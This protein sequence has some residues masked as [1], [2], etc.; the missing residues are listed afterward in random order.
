[1]CSLRH[2]SKL[3]PTE[4]TS[5]P[6]FARDKKM[7]AI[8]D[9]FTAVVAERFG[10]ALLTGALLASVL[11][12][13]V[14]RQHRYVTIFGVLVISV[15]STLLASYH[16]FDSVSLDCDDL[17]VCTWTERYGLLNPVRTSEIKVND[18]ESADFIRLERSSVG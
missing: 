7:T 4:L 14:V 10:E 11:F 18:I 13:L 9:A 6:N 5:E 12:T 16:N 2:L 17:K 8:F 3:Q 15:C 1:M